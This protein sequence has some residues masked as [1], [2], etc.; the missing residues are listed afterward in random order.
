MKITLVD[1]PSFDN[2]MIGDHEVLA[3]ISA[4]ASS[5]YRKGILLSGIIYLSGIGLSYL[6]TRTL[7]PVHLGMFQK[8]CGSSA[9]Q[10]VLLTTTRWS[11][12]YRADEGRQEEHLRKSLY[13]KELVAKGATIERFMGTR[14]SGLELI[15]KLIKKEPVSL[16][17]QDQM[18]KE[19]MTLAETD[20]GKHLRTRERL[21]H[22]DSILWE[23]K[24]VIERYDKRKETPAQEPAKTKENWKRLW[25]KGTVSRFAFS[26]YKST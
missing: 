23:S 5:A 10:N 3:E 11:N 8:L 2:S 25:L 24:V 26:K 16:L 20:A 9:L 6:S 1:T 15:H 17:I 21:E 19:N 12:V 18:V 7:L 4:W 13:W 14:E 22:L